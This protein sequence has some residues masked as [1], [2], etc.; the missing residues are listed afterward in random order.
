MN[1]SSIGSLRDFFI[2]IYSRRS[3]IRRILLPMLII[4]LLFT[5]FQT[6]T[7][8]VSGEIIV[9]SKEIRQVG[10]DHLSNANT[11]QHLPVTLKDMETEA[12]ILRSL[13]L[14]QNTVTELHQEGVFEL[15]KSVIDTWIKEPLKIFLIEPIF[16]SKEDQEQNINPDDQIVANLTKKVIAGLQINPLPGSNVIVVSYKTENIKEGQ[17][18]VNRLMDKFLT[19]R[20]DLMLG[21][22]LE[23]V[24]MTKKKIYQERLNALENKKL[25][26]LKQ[27]DIHHPQEELTLTLHAINT[28]T[29]QANKLADKLLEAKKWQQYLQKIKKNLSSSEATDLSLAYSFTRGDVGSAKIEMGSEMKQQLEI[30]RTLQSKY[31]TALLLFNEDNLKVI[32][33]K[34]QLEMA[35][36]RLIDLIENRLTEQTQNIKV[37][38]AVTEQKRKRLIGL[39]ERA[40]LATEILVK[41]DEINAELKSIQTSLFKYGQHLDEQH[42]ASLISQEKWRNVRVLNYAPV[43]L[44][45]SSPGKMVVLIAGLIGSIV[46][47]ISIAFLYEL[48]DH[49]FHS[50]IQ[51]SKR[52]KLPVIAVIDDVNGGQHYAFSLHPIRFCKWLTQ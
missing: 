11:T 41:E 46:T 30:I 15:K 42:S 28:E 35:K 52:L 3:F 10:N 23:T 32:Q 25:D 36:I 26:L 51:V 17:I 13:P 18:I 39:K 12:T 44:G 1:N 14:I 7:Y 48:F 27:N 34:E 49:R 24:F 22:P 6:K 37:L 16:G 20:N 9:L 50:H 45:P 21:T 8:T 43:P 31:D 5:V 33:P 4:V 47:A 2:S 29:T 40:S 38:R 19:R